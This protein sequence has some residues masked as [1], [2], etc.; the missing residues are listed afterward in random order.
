M[1]VPPSLAG[2]G[3]KDELALAEQHIL[4]LEI[5]VRFTVAAG[6]LLH[7]GIARVAAL[8]AKLSTAVGDL[9]RVYLRVD[10]PSGSIQAINNFRS[11]VYG[12]DQST[13]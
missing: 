7:K 3:G 10:D 12:S 5:K 8:S 11:S 6:K 1:P 4:L 2:E 13:C 9:S